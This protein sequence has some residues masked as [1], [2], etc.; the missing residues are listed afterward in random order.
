TTPACAR[1]RGRPVR[2]RPGTA[3][4]R[5]RRR[6]RPPPRPRRRRRANGSPS[7]GAG[8]A[9]RPPARAPRARTTRAAAAGP[10]A[11]RTST[12]TCESTRVSELTD[13]G[14]IVLL[15]AGSFSLALGA[16]KLTELFPIPAPALFL[17]LAAGASDIWPGLQRLSTVD[18]ERIAVVALIVI[19]FDGGML[20][21]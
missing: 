19:L 17:V 18:V 15:V 4:A 14:L 2:R 10:L 9:A 3:P 20:V 1:R 21:G 16:H 7:F 13:F 5:R 11:G 6:S 12:S 8:T